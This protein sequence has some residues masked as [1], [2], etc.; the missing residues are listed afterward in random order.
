LIRTESAT[1]STAIAAAERIVCRG[2]GPTRLP[3]ES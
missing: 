3:S 2:V 1:H